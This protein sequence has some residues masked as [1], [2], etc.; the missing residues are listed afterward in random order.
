VFL[1]DAGDCAIYDYRP[2]AC[3]RYFV[4]SDPSDCDTLVKPGHEVLNFISAGAEIEAS[5]ALE[6]FESGT[7]AAMVLAEL[8]KDATP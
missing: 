1:T 6:V 4:V 8:E 7:L 3:R 2:L 5:A